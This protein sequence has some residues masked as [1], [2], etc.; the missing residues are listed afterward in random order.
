ML[1]FLAIFSLMKF[2]RIIYQR[3]REFKIVHAPGKDGVMRGKRMPRCADDPPS[4]GLA[5]PSKLPRGFNMENPEH[6]SI[7]AAMTNAD[8]SGGDLEHFYEVDRNA[9]GF[10]RKN[11]L[12]KHQPNF[13]VPLSLLAPQRNRDL[14]QQDFKVMFAV[15]SCLGEKGYRRVTKQMIASRTAGV[16][17]STRPGWMGKPL[18]E[19]QVEYSLGK[20]QAKGFI[21]R[22]FIPTKFTLI[23]NPSRLDLEDFLVIAKNWK[24]KRRE[25]GRAIRI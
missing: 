18:T 15:N 5:L 16:K 1:E 6:R 25:L 12:E 11:G 20:L 24:K 9:R 21:Y 10:L 14:R 19:R 13:D 22:V 7:G 4:W 3:Q 8:I 2:S 17:D 23:A